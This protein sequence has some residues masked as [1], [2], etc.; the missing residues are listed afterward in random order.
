MMQQGRVGLRGPADISGGQD[1]RGHV[2][3]AGRGAAH[4]R[5]TR[6]HS[7]T[8]SRRQ[9]EARAARCTARASRGLVS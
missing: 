3:G 7:F 1:G 2:I 5:L 8:A 9:R 6:I 4:Y